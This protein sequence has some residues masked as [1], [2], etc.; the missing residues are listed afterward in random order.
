MLRRQESPYLLSA[1]TNDVE[2][3]K[4]NH[5]CVKQPI[6]QIANNAPNIRPSEI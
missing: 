6:R 2:A 5:M 4:V 3:Q 1:A